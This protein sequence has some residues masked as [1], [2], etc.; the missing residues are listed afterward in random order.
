MD[1]VL[2]EFQLERHFYQA[3][4]D[5]DPK[6]DESRLRAED[7][8]GD[9]FAGTDDGGRK[10]ETGAEITQFPEKTSLAAPRFCPG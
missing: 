7:G 2:A 5:D 9:E 1:G 6:R 10:D 3:T 8:G 4:D